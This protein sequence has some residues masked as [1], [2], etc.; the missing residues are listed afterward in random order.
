MKAHSTGGMTAEKQ[1]Q[2]RQKRGDLGRILWG[3]RELTKL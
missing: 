3:S 1:K 2:Q